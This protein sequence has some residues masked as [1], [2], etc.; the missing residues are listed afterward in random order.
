M[1]RLLGRAGTRRVYVGV[2]SGNARRCPCA[3]CHIQSTKK[4]QRA[5]EKRDWQ[6]ENR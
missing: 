1:S 3:E 6:K 2:R 5:R 4:A